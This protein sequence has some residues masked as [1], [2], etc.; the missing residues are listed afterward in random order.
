MQLCE[1]LSVD[2]LRAV[3][4]KEKLLTVSCTVLCVFWINVMFK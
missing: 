3:I 4:E 2:A 1:C